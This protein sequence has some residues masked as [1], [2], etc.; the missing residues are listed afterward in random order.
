LEGSLEGG[1]LKKKWR[2]SKCRKL[3]ERGHKIILGNELRFDEIM[4][5]AERV[6][7]G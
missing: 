3:K 4:I 6:L 7:V 5:M 1:F 2:K